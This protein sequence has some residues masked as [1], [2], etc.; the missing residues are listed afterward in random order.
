MLVNNVTGTAISSNALLQVNRLVPLAEALDAPGLGWTTNGTPPWVG[1]TMVAQ[2]GVDAARSGRIGDDGT[3]SFRTTVAGPGT[4]SFWWRVSSQTNSDRLRFYIGSSEQQNISGEVNWT[5]RSLPV[6]GSGNQVLEWRYTKGASTATGQDSGWVDQIHYIP[7]STPTAPLMAIQPVNRTVVSPTTVSLNAVAIGS[8]PLAYQWYFRGNLLTNGSGISGA[9]T[10]NLTITSAGAAQ[11]GDYHVVVTN[12]MGSVTSASASLTVITAP[13]ITNP[14]PSQNVLAGST[15]TFNVGVLGMAPLSYQ[16]M[17]NGTNLA[18]VSGRVSGATS[19]TLTLTGVQLAQEGMYSVLVSN[20]A[21]VAISSQTGGALT[22]WQAART[23][24][25]ADGEETALQALVTG[26]GTVRFSWKVSSETNNDAFRFLVGGI[27]QETISGEVDWRAESFEVPAGA[28]LLQ[29]R[30]SKDA[31]GSAGQDAGWVDGVEF[32]VTNELTAPLIATQPDSQTVPTG[33]TIAFQAGAE[34]T[35]PLNYQWRFNGTPLQNGGGISG[36]KTPRLTLANVQSVHA[37][38]YSLLVSNAVGTDT[39]LD[40]ALTIIPP[41]T[42]TAPVITTPLASQNVSENARVIFNVVA[43][44]T[45]PL[46]YQWQFNGTNLADSPDVSGVTT[47][48]LVLSNALPTQAGNYSVLVSNALGGASATASLNVLSLADAAGAPY[49]DMRMAGYTSWVAQASANDFVRSGVIPDNQNTRLETWVDGPGTI[50]FRWKVSSEN[51]NDQLRFYIGAAEM[52]RISGEVDWE[53]Q[54][55]AVPAGEQQLL[56][57]R[58]SKDAD[59]AAGQDAAWVD[60]VR[61]VF[62]GTAI[63]PAVTNHPSSQSVLAGS[64]A[65]FTAN[66]GGSFPLTYQWLLNGTNLPNGG[67]VSGAGTPRLT[68]TGVQLWQAGDYSLLV[69]NA[70]GTVTTLAATLSVAPVASAPAITS[71]PVSQTTNEG[72]AV[73]FSVSANGAAPLIYQWQFNGVD[74][75]DGS[76]VSGATTPTLTLLNVGADQIGGYSVLVT[77][78]AGI[79]AS[80][81]ASL[82][83]LSLAEVVG[84]P[85]LDFTVDGSLPWIAQT[86]Q[87]AAPQSTNGGARLTVSALPTISSQPG[88]RT[89][90]AGNNASFTVGIGGTA[91][92]NI[93]WRFNGT[94]LVD[95]D[96]ISGANTTT[97]TLTEVEAIRAGS[98]SV[99]ISNAVGNITSSNA[100]LTVLVPPSIVSHPSDRTV[101]EGAAVSFTVN[102]TGTAPLTYR[103]RRNGT[104]LVNGGSISGATSATLSL[105]NA[106]PSQVGSYSV[107][108]SNSVGTAISDNAQLTVIAA[109]TL[110]EAMNA[111][112]LSWDAFID[113]PWIVQSNVT[114]DGEAAAQSGNAAHGASTW[115]ETAVT[116]PGTIRFW[117]K[118][119]SQ[120]NADW[121]TF[122]VGG[123]TWGQ[124]SGE[125]DWQKMSFDLPAGTVALRWTY[126]KNATVIG[127]LDRA[128]LDEV[129]F[130]PTT[131]PSVPVIVNQPTPQ[132]VNPGTTVTLTV[133]ALG[134]GP[135]SYQ[136]RFNGQNLG[137]N[138]NTLGSKSPTLTLFNV[139]SPQAGLYD[140]T[141]RNPYSLALSAQVLL[142]VIPVIPLGTALDTTNTIFWTTGGYS[143]WRGQTDYNFDRIDAAQSGPLPH[144]QSNW[145]QTI[146]SGPG[147]ITFWWKSSSETNRDRLRFLINGVEQANITGE[148]DWRK[149]TFPILLPQTELRWV[150]T[151]DASGSAGLDRGWVDIV[152]FG[153]SAPIITNASS[154]DYYIDQGSSVRLSVDATGTTP[155]SYQWQLNGTN[156]VNSATNFPGPGGLYGATGN[157]RLTISNAQ[158]HQSGIYSAIVNNQAG[159]AIG[160]P[161]QVTVVPALP[162]GPALNTNLVWENG[163]Y[164]FWVGTT[165]ISRDGMAARNG[166]LDNGRSALMS[167]TVV[168]A[169]QLKFWWRASTE[170]NLDYVTFSI[171]SNEMARISGN[172]NWQQRTFDLNEIGETYLLQ[173]EYTK[174]G[175]LTNGLD[176][177][178]VD[179]VTYSAVPPTITTQPISQTVDQGSTVTF[180]AA[181]Q[182]TPPF[183]YQWRRGTTPLTDDGNISGSG[184]ATLRITDVQVSQAG[185]YS[186]AV[187]NGGGSALTASA[188]LTVNPTFPLGE[189]LDANNFT[190]SPGSPAWVGQ[191]LVTHDGVDAARSPV[192]GSSQTATMQTTITGPGTISYWWKTSSETNRDYLIFYA[193]S[194]ST[195]LARISGDRAW[196]QTN[197][198]L[199]SGNQTLRWTYSKNGSTNFGQDRGWVDQFVFT[200]VP[201]TITSQPVGQT[202]DQGANA[203]FSVAASGTPPLTY[204]W[205]H[206]GIEID[207]ATSATFVLSNAQPYHAGNFSVVVA[208]GG[209]SVTSANAPLVVAPTMPLEEAL[210]GSNLVWTTTGSGSAAWIGQSLTTHD[211]VDSARI[212]GVASS[213][214]ASMQTSVTGPGSV[215]FW[216][217]V[218]SEP[219]NDR[220]TFYTNNTEAV[221]IS[222]EVNWQ[223]KTFNLGPGTH[224]FR[225]TYSKNSGSTTGGQDRAW[226]DQVAFGPVAPTITSQ[227]TNLNVDVGASATFRAT[228]SGTP[229]FTYQWQFDGA[230]LTNGTGVSGATS[231][232]LVLSAVQLSRAGTYRVVVTG[233]G[234]T[235]VSA[236]ATLGVF[237][238]LTLAEALDTVDMPG[239]TWTTTGSPPW[240]GS[241][242]VSHDGVDAARSGAIG[243]ST[244]NSMSAVVSGPIT[245]SFWW[246]VSSETNDR[247]FFY[248]NGAEQGRIS[249]EVDWQFKTVNLNSGNQTLKWT[250]FKNSGTTGGQ[251][252]GWVDQVSLGLVAPTITTQ[253]ANITVDSGAIATFTVGAAA[254]PPVFYTWFFNGAPLVNGG[255]IAGATSATLTITNAQIGRVGSYSVMVSNSVGTVTSSTATLAL[256]SVVSINQALDGGL[257]FTTG[258]TAQPWRGQQPISHDGIDAA[259]SGTVSNSTYS[260][261]KTTVTGPGPLTFWWTV[262][263][264]LDR[265]F[266][267]FMVDGVEV[268]SLKISGEVPWQ[269]A[270]YNVPSGS[271]E[272]QW[273]YSKNS[274][275]DDG[276]DRGWVDQVFFGTNTPVSV[277]PP[278]ILIQPGS[279]VI[280]AGEDVDLS[281]AAASAYP[282]TYHWLFNGTNAVQNGSD[283]VGATTSQLTLLNVGPAYAG[284][285]FVIVSNIGGAVLSTSARLTVNPSVDLADAVD[286]LDLFVLTDGDAPWIGHT[287]VTHDGTDAARSGR[288]FDGQRSTIQTALNGPGMLTFWWK[289]SSQTNADALTFSINGTPQ[290]SISGEV[291]WQQGIFNLP[292]G[293]Q[294][295]EWTYLK[296]ESLSEGSDRGWLDQ[297]V[298]GPGSATNGPSSGVGIGI[299]VTTNKVLLT[300]TGNAQKTYRVYYKNSLADTEWTLLDGEISLTWQIVNGSVVSDVVLATCEDVLAGPKRFYRVLEF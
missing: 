18:N 210:D 226:V 96:S 240:I 198:T 272:L 80:A 230:D 120:T 247:L 36:V 109:M 92:F 147:A 236:D 48:R 15:V 179:Q 223:L 89:V 221:R 153:P 148:V 142:D 24:A 31:T 53:Q 218:S 29:W 289:V 55:F 266:L 74:L 99:V 300:W 228:V 9:T 134:T 116:G 231:S 131:G 277:D 144:G 172:H 191:S 207:G 220:L 270:T 196:Q 46:I 128:W 273:R 248:V 94:P 118:V 104:N 215:T 161:M 299:S 211:G 1:Q 108:V 30:Y 203:V 241:G 37:G 278:V 288:I 90:V 286:T 162:L 164:S 180:T 25:I 70:A 68:L 186:L 38:N 260:W 174:N 187:F 107:E 85:Y 170:T 246:K 163:G 255:G 102:A 51:V 81:P 178:F 290:S 59:G 122:S 287:V 41:P 32:I 206:D 151:K 254:T 75:A 152:E 63:A 50:T 129:D 11:A 56:K 253:P 298:F 112:Y 280:D 259:Q 269:Q 72:A 146:L 171:N 126:S 76:A 84:A 182:G 86:G 106:Q 60:D 283:A 82:S 252:R 103:W 159:T 235:T 93:Q 190:W 69:S 249:G 77:N 293:P 139:Q 10:T 184:T 27:E 137:D 114:H 150:Y 34:G 143:P 149:R 216:W 214:N 209:G 281:V 250:Y 192:I 227:P 57:W 140:V 130:V 136:W 177:V 13:V 14:P 52:M 224:A 212:G 100:T 166:S 284:D 101:N 199:P 201:P 267:K 165:S 105:N 204:Q 217:K 195:E 138:E 64:M 264:E 7:A 276:Q 115:L 141:V 222:G 279:Q 110:G 66:V 188:Q 83:V 213:G 157:H 8:T 238:I 185:A 275:V 124:I 294:I 98:Y 274:S 145:I 237:P 183:I 154:S 19:A 258:G 225:W 181:A 173:W 123:S 168:G 2:D 88:N 208:N 33:A 285:Y 132:A 239:L 271:H 167:T 17:C 35:V 295:L 175:T 97:L 160:P 251:D 169:G 40:A 5:W 113:T 43:A 245:L 119:S 121:L 257:A 45:P 71:Q 262:S 47:A 297:L 12:T 158:P 3:T 23:S 194:G 22:T 156:L 65:I 256:S 205:R 133:G 16:W 21:G 176:Q 219:S 39:S 79:A 242:S 4:V 155:F 91:P 61:Y 95:N 232:N 125:V 49:L 296:N 20:A 202:V 78:E 234:G 28:H 87:S 111:P 189:A 265:D 292:S 127:G 193:G 268:P 263:S 197:F 243:N 244:S 200:P 282:L 67:G 261:I 6:S 26:P 117:W 135:L 54:S 44:G 229:P 42:I 62:T 233:L 291:D 73:S 58:Y